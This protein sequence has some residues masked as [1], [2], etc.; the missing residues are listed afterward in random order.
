MNIITLGI[1]DGSTLTT[2]LLVGLF[3]SAASSISLLPVP[4][5]ASYGN[6]AQTADYDDWEQA[7]TYPDW[8]QT[9]DYDY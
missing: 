8:A 5:T 9:A 2:Y 7:G 1:G 6:W 3:P 4:F